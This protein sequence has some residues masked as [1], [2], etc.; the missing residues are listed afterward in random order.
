M[1]AFAIGALLLL[2]AIVAVR[3]IAACPLLRTLAASA[4]CWADRVNGN[5][6]N[7]PQRVRGLLP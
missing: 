7:R 4:N 2:L 5:E 3:R 1:I 6:T